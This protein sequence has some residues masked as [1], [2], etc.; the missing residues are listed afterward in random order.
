MAD[1][2]I[3]FDDS[4]YTRDTVEGLRVVVGIAKTKAH[5]YESALRLAC[6]LIADSCQSYEEANTT[7]GWMAHFV[8]TVI[9]RKL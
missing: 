3:I 1:I 4:D 8:S 2:S 9:E 7:D 6:E 5:V